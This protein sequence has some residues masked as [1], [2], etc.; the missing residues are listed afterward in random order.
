M[1]KQIQ[2]I[3]SIHRHNNV[4]LRKRHASQRGDVIYDVVLL[5]ISNK[6]I[7][8][9]GAMLTRLTTCNCALSGGLVLISDNPVGLISPSVYKR[10]PEINEVASFRFKKMTE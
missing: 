4:T 2:L 1:Y 10:F 5:R 9:Y 3:K 7:Y 6:A 8:M